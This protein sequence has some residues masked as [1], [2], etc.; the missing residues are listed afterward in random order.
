[1]KIAI[2]KIT[3][4]K[5][6]VRQYFSTDALEELAD[7]LKRNG[8][9]Q[10]IVVVTSKSG[11]TIVAGERRYRAA[12]ALGWT[13]IEAEVRD[14]LAT[15]EARTVANIAENVARDNLTT[16]EKA[17]AAQALKL[18]GYS[19]ERAGKV[20]RM[21]RSHT[22]NLSRALQSLDPEI[23]AAW[24]ADTEGEIA[25]DWILELSAVKS[26]AEQ[27]D[28]WEAK[29][30]AEGEPV[31]GEGGEGEGTGDGGKEKKGAKS[32]KLQGYASI[33]LLLDAVR[34][35]KPG[36]VPTAQACLEWVCLRRKT[37]PIQLAKKGGV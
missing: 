34:Q 23:L 25:L 28:M 13:E 3:A 26:R 29:A 18:L 20:L 35:A 8:L 16:Y 36:N 10:P 6:N 7:S 22:D 2:E 31:E 21:S 24:K 33:L 4:S 30:R 15:D 37:P 5:N 32:K 1:M 11:Y 12:K 19:G 27:R 14:D 17:Q 9:L